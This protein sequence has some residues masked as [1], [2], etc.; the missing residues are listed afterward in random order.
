MLEIDGANLDADT[1][2]TF[3]VTVSNFLGGNDTASF[4]VERSGVAA[5]EVAILPQGIDPDNV[6]VADRYVIKNI[7]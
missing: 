6:K 4:S 5:P 7:C 1:A 2:Y 3:T